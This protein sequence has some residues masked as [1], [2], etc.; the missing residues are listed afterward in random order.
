MSLGGRLDVA[1][2]GQRFIQGCLQLCFC[3]CCDLGGGADFC[4]WGGITGRVLA[5]V[6]SIGFSNRGTA[7]PL[8]LNSGLISFVPLMIFD[9]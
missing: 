8:P 2:H 7:L 6:S 5:M 4:L 1:A 3:A 9:C